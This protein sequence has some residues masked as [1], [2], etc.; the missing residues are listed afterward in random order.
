MKAAKAVRSNPLKLHL[1]EDLR[2]PTDHDVRFVLQTR[3]SAVSSPI[4][5]F[6]GSKDLHGL[7]LVIERVSTECLRARVFSHMEQRV[8][9]DY[10]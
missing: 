10:L 2:P 5:T 4:W 7:P 6:D 9:G 8:G 3:I 1:A